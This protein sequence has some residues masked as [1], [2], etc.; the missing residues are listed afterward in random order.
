MEESREEEGQGQWKSFEEQ[1]QWKKPERKEDNDNELIS[2]IR[3]V[4]RRM[5]LLIGGKATKK[6]SANRQ[7]EDIVAYSVTSSRLK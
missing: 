6:V 4:T 7:T 5:S 2:R 3:A 1:G